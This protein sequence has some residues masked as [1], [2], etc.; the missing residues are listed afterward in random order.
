MLETFLGWCVRVG[1]TGRFPVTGIW[2]DRIHGEVFRI[3]LGGHQEIWCHAGHV[4]IN[5][6]RMLIG[7]VYS[8][9]YNHQYCDLSQH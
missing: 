9:G 7:W 2:L 5:Y 8:R 4:L 3:N 6:H 1:M